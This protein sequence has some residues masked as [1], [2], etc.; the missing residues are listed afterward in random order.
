MFIEVV[1][2]NKR[3]R[4]PNSLG[5]HGMSWPVIKRP[6]IRVVKVCDPLS[7]PDERHLGT[8]KCKGSKLEGEPKTNS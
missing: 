6:N 3:M 5:L 8:L 1:G 7:H 2:Q 4:H